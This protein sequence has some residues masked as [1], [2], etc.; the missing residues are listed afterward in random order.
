M[1]KGRRG[2]GGGRREEG[3][4][5]ARREC[6]GTVLGGRGGRGRPYRPQR[7]EGVA[8]LLAC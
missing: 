7:A 1:K 2:W 8:V 3:Q 5:G 6:D 4:G